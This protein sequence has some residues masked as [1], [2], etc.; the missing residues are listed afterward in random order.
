MCSWPV[1]NKSSLH[2][3][4]SECIV[5]LIDDDEFHFILDQHAVLDF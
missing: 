3:D 2:R 1:N 4:K 5:I